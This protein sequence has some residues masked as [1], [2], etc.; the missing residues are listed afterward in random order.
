[1]TL[2]YIALIELERNEESELL[3][4]VFPD[5]PGCI[6]AGKS[7]E[8]AFRNAHE[9]LTL[10]INGLRED[11]LPIPTPSSLENIE[12]HW[13]DYADWQ[14]TKFAVAY[15]NLLP[16]STTKKYT[17]SMDARLMAKIDAVARNRSAFLATAAEYFLNERV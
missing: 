1:M 17:I 2:R 8:D 4:V 11:G 13:P 3:G 12:A 15:I 10:H 16:D 14:G 6:S 9:A 5:L 7:Y